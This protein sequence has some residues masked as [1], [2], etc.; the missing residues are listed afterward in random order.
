MKTK[1]KVTVALMLTA[2]LVLAAAGCNRNRYDP[3]KVQGVTDTEIL[4]GNAAAI[5]GAY[6]SVGVPF[7]A[8]LEAVF[9]KVNDAGGIG[10]RTIKFKHYDDGFDAAAGKTLTEKLV[11]DDKVFALVGHF[12]TPTVGAT[13]DYIKETGVPAV[14]Y[15]TGIS[16]LY[17]EAATEYARANVPVQPIYNTEGRI[18]LARAVKSPDLF[19]TVAK[20]GVI[21]SDD[22]AGIGMKTGI[23]RQAQDVS[24]VTLSYQKIAATNTDATAAVAQLKTFAPQ[25]IIIATNQAPLKVAFEK[26]AE[27]SMEVPCITSY[28]NASVATAG[29]STTTKD[30]VVTTTKGLTDSYSATRKL[31]ASGWLDINP[32]TPGTGVPLPGYEALGEWTQD[33]V[34]FAVLMLADTATAGYFGNA[35]AMAG[36][37][38][39][40]IFVEGLRRVA[41]KDDKTLTWKTYLDALESSNVHIPMGGDLDF[42]NGQR[43]GIASMNLSVFVPGD[44][45]NEIAANQTAGTNAF[46]RVKTLASLEAILG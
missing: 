15:A 33:Y 7:N 21:Y 11:E 39:A 14:Y 8:A 45:P 46:S 4:V 5:S 24:G 40:N 2:M 30:D 42:S 19:G 16:Q 36:Y 44:K 25:V 31:Y 37:V 3:N 41:A 35:Y 10:G 34:D 38:A 27:N 9:K 28:V 29:I 17:D 1:L 26:L 6:A 22:D 43:L 23:E 20:V 32:A 13:I 18:M 12:G